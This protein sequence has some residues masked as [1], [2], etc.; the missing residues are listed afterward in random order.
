VER[1]IWVACFNAK[2]HKWEPGEPYSNFLDALSDALG[3]YN[4][5]QMVRITLGN[6]EWG[7]S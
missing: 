1:Q 4:E 5:G 2:T 6:W 7:V 3:W